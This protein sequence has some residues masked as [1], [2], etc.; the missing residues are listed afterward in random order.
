MRYVRDQAVHKLI[1]S[2]CVAL[3]LV[4]ESRIKQAFISRQKM[5]VA[6][7]SS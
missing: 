1:S 6:V 5:L 2:S 4:K 7:L 3:T